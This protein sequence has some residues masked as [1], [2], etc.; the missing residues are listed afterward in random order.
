MTEMYVAGIVWGEGGG[1]LRTSGREGWMDL[2]R[3]VGGLNRVSRGETVGAS[4]DLS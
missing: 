3:V 2:N 1:G 4:V